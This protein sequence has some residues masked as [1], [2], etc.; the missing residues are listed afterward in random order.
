MSNFVEKKKEINFVE[1][2]MWGAVTFGRMYSGEKISV[3]DVIRE[4]KKYLNIDD[5]YMADDVA[6]VTF[7]RVN[8][9]YKSVMRQSGVQFEMSN[10]ERIDFAML[11][12]NEAKK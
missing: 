7:Y 12:L 11:L 1:A 10:Q 4:F 3:I 6:A 9:N 2:A 5:E 8:K